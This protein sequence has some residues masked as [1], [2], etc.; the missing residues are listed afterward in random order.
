MRLRPPLRKPKNIFVR[1]KIE[2]FMLKAFRE[3]M[4]IKF[5]NIRPSPTVK[6]IHSNTTRYKITSRPT[7]QRIGTAMAK[8]II[9]TVGTKT[10]IPPA[11]SK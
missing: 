7:F 5:K 1:I 4:S 6:P 8:Q 9:V 2:N 11:R 10:M 3:V